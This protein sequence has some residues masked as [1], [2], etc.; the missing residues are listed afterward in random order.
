MLLCKHEGEL[1]AVKILRQTT[2]D[3]DMANTEFI[4][5]VELLMRMRH[6]NIIQ[7][8]GKGGGSTFRVIR[9]VASDNLLVLG[10]A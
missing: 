8:I 6:K 7:F 3:G 9:Q 5:E 1:V 4:R 10:F 2:L